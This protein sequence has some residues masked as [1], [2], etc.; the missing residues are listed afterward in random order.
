MQ[1]LVPLSVQHTCNTQLTRGKVH[2][3]RHKSIHS[4]Y[5]VLFYRCFFNTAWSSK[6]VIFVFMKKI[7]FVTINV[8][9]QILVPLSVQQSLNTHVQLSQGQV[10]MEHHKSMHIDSLSLLYRCLSPVKFERAKNVF[11]KAFICVTINV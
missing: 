10:H 11:N 5:I 8:Q 7:N 2:M 9:M 4:H 1:I 6:V 3:E